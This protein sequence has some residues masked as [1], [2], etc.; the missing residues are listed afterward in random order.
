M[1]RWERIIV[2]AKG[3][4][5]HAK[6][7]R[8]VLVGFALLL[9]LA[10]GTKCHAAEVGFEAGSQVLRHPAPALVV[11]LTQ[12]RIAGDVD[13]ECGVLL[14]GGDQVNGTRGVMGL[15]CMLVDGFGP[16]ELGI[17]AA[18]FNHTD[19]LNGSL[20]NFSL[21]LAWRINDRW[22]LTYRHFS[23]SGTTDINTG[24]DLAL[25]T[26]RFK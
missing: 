10:F 20:M 3:L 4:F 24:R 21:K 7:V 13:G 6:P 16:V 23:N 8:Y 18:Y 11:T 9:L 22:G 1:S 14:V 25:V 19:D 15:Q 26:Y 5:P 2:W 17:G 12:P